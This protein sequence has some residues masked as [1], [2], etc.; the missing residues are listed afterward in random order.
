[1]STTAGERAAVHPVQLLVIGR[2][3]DEVR[4]RQAIEAFQVW[5]RANRHLGVSPIA[6]AGRRASGATSCQTRGVL[7]PRQGTL[8]GLVI[9]VILLALPA[10]GAAA[11]VGWT[12]GSLIFGLAGLVG[13]IPSGQVGVMVLGLTAGSAALAALLAGIMGA[14]LG[15]LVG[16]IVGAIDVSARSLSRSETARALATLSAGSWA[17]VARAEPGVTRLVRD[18]LA[19][20]GADPS[21]ELP[22]LQGR[23]APTNLSGSQAPS[24]PATSPPRTG[25]V[26]G[27]N[28]PG[29]R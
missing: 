15:G 4:A 13:A 22:P 21:I 9:G 16:L 1:M 24:P 17:V 7:R 26:A 6:V 27:A 5:R 19:R 29:E 12:L 20:L 3:D 8:I 2:F 18:E 25:T 23:S 11:L 10:A 28:D 14:I